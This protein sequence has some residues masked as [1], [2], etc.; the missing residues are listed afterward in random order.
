MTKTFFTAF[1]FLTLLVA[2]GLYFYGTKTI[3]EMN[4]PK[5]TEF[6]KQTEQPDPVNWIDFHPA[7]N[8]FQA[9]FPAN[10]QQATDRAL[11]TKTKEPKQYEMY[12]SEY[13]GEIYMI[14][15]ISFPATE[16]IKD[17]DAT[18]EGIIHD[19]VASNPGNKLVSVKPGVYRGSKDRDFIITNPDY[20]ITG[21]TIIE[22]NHLFVL[23][24][25]AKT[26]ANSK[27][28]GSDYF[29]NSFK[30]NDLSVESIA[31]NLPMQK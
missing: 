16:S 12:I 14:S 4:T 9:K 18:I 15:V 5:I 10:P 8:K 22:K 7:S 11:D 3:S 17:E 24:A 27:K 1:L 2:L 31:P 20:T 30:I 26:A 13:N 23:S 6:V 29:L 25:L 21:R 19:M 28:D